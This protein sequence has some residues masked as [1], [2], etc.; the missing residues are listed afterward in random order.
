MKASHR[1]ANSAAALAL[2]VAAVMTFADGVDAKGG[3]AAQNVIVAAECG[4]VGAASAGYNKS[5]ARVTIMF[6]MQ[7]AASGTS[8]QVTATDDGAQL[9]SDHLDSLGS[10]WTLMRTYDSPKGKRVVMVV[11]DAD[12]GSQHCVAMVSYKV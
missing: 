8:W 10:N 5:G 4:G 3:D 2:T 1:F 12:D 6:Q 11:A 9:F 7:S